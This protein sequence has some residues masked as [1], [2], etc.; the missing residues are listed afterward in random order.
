MQD[1][2]GTMSEIELWMQGVPLR[3][4]LGQKDMEKRT[5]EVVRRDNGS[6]DFVSWDGL[7]NYIVKLL[8]TI[9]VLNPPPSPPPVTC[10]PLT[11]VH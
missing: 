6:K 11:Q 10:I 2:V 7:S 9:Q 1:C 3:I 4:G 8:D 5:V